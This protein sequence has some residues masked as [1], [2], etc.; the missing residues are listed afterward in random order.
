MASPFLSISWKSR[1]SAAI[2]NHAE[3]QNSECALSAMSTVDCWLKAKSLRDRRLFGG[4][5]ERTGRMS[6]Y[7]LRV[8]K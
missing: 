5:A 1:F 2:V 7:K 3:R 4:G 8:P 6:D